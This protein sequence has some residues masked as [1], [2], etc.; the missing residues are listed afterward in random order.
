MLHSSPPVAAEKIEA[1][2]VFDRIDDPKQARLE[3][4]ELR[5]IDLA[6]EHGML[7]TLT[8]AYACLGDAREP[9]LARVRLRTDVIRHQDKHSIASLPEKCRIRVQ[10]ASKEPGQQPRLQMKQEAD[11]DLP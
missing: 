2:T 9:A 11:R 5:G 1:E 10:V 7:H 8:E 4:D 6:F 3:R